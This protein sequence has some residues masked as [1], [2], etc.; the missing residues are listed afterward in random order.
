LLPLSAAARAAAPASPDVVVV[1]VQLLEARVGLE[2]VGE[3][4]GA[5][6]AEVHA[7][8]AQRIQKRIVAPEPKH[9]VLKLLTRGVERVRHVDVHLAALQMASRPARDVPGEKG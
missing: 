3:G 6:G 8:Q 1:Q 5:G 9:G 7:A 2:R 4:G